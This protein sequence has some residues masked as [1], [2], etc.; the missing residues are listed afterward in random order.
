[1]AGFSFRLTTLMRLRQTARD[2][3]RQELA[4]E[5]QLE[6]S[7]Y[8]RLARLDRELAELRKPAGA[9]G[10]DGLIDIDR[11]RDT[12]RYQSLLAAKRQ[13]A[14]QECESCSAQVDRLRQ[15]LVEADRELKSL[16]KLQARQQDRHRRSQHKHELRQLDEVGIR[17]AA[18][19]DSP[20]N[21]GV[22][23]G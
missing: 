9:L 20:P 21:L 3:C 5:E 2:R 6:R 14:Q 12:A 13:A 4:A 17:S 1:V 19:G 15:S 7:I 18:T 11:L 10:H 16:E 22:V 8:E 23:T